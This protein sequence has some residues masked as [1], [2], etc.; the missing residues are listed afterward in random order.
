MTQTDGEGMGYRE[1]GK[2]W[3]ERKGERPRYRE[4]ENKIR[5]NDSHRI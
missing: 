1:K 5:E 4:S 2:T 3:V